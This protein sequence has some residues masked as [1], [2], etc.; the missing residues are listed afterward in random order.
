MRILTGFKQNLDK[1]M[2]GA[3]RMPCVTAANVPCY[4]GGPLFFVYSTKV[5]S[6]CW[7]SQFS[8]T[9]CFQRQLLAADHTVL[10]M[11]TQAVW[12]KLV[13][14]WEVCF[15]NDVHDPV[16]LPDVVMKM[17]PVLQTAGRQLVIGSFL[18][19]V[20]MAAFLAILTCLIIRNTEVAE[21]YS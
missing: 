3:N 5:V 16:N 20:K 11:T 17:G 10:L 8:S 15:H 13:A 2:R 6:K 18:S 7:P 19:L 14:L 4:P 21:I 12:A 9:L 1:F